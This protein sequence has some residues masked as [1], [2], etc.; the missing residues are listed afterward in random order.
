MLKDLV[1][2]LNYEIELKLNNLPVLSKLHLSSL[3][4]LEMVN[5]PEVAELKVQ[6][7][8][9]FPVDY[10]AMTKLKSLSIAMHID[11]L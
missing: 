11:G 10:S 3:T 8:N 1:L 7:Y 4:K 2:D 9:Y 6:T 5:C